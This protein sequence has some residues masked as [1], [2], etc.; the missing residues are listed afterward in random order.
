MFG[1]AEVTVGSAR[2]H[3][4]AA[5]PRVIPRSSYRNLR[6]SIFW[7]PSISEERGRWLR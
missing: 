6:V 5:W 2:T 7:S 3:L 4:S 1:W